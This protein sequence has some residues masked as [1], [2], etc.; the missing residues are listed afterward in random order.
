[1]LRSTGLAAIMLASIGL[2]AGCS[3]NQD[4][5]AAS[6]VLIGAAAGQAVGSGSGRAAATLVGAAVGAQIGANQPTPQS[7]IYRNNQ[8][9][10][11]F[12]A[13]CS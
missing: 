10:E 3:S 4:L 2:V 6:G 11:T 13:P 5:N 7:C 12:Q 9:G 1:M 8:T